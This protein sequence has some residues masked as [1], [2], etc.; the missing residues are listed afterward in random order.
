MSA[1]KLFCTLVLI[2]FAYPGSNAGVS[3]AGFYLPDSIQEVTLRYERAGKL[4]VLP[5]TINDTLHLNLILDTGCRNMIL[6]GNHLSKHFN[7]HP[8]RKA[9]FSG[10]G[11]GKSLVGDLALDNKVAIDAVIG[12]RIPIVLVSRPRMF[13]GMRNIDGIIGYDILIKFEVELHPARQFI[14]FRPAA[15]ATLGAAYNRLPIRIDDSRPI[16]QST[17]FAN[18]QWSTLDIM[19]DTGSSLGLLLKTENAAHSWTS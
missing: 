3:T 19:I 14:T 11:A 10:L 1:L 17:L 8:G 2:A 13:Q 9:T 7:I 6:F 18:G 15:T 12:E 4:I 5:V 16:V